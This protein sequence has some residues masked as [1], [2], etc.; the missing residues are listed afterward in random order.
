MGAYHGDNLLSSSKQHQ[1]GKTS[2]QHNKRILSNMMIPGDRVSAIGRDN[3]ICAADY[4]PDQDAAI[5][6]TVINYYYAIES[7][8]E[9]TT[10]NSAGRAIIRMLEDK[11][12][13]AIRPAILWCYFDEPPS[14][15]RN[16]LGDSSFSQQGGDLEKGHTFRKLTLDDARRLSIVSFS[17]SP[18]DDE[19]PIDCNYATQDDVHCIVMHGIVSI[20]HH[21]TSDVRLAVAS[22]YDST[23]K[24]MDYSEIFF[25]LEDEESL[26]NI[27]N[28]EWLGE[29]EQDAING[30]PNGYGPNDGTN[31]T[32][33]NGT[34]VVDVDESKEEED[35]N[36][37]LAYALSVP[38]LIVLA[39]ALLL[40]KSKNKRKMKTK[41]QL[42]AARSFHNVLIGTGD[43]PNS[44]HEGMYHYTQHGV[45]YLSTNCQTCIETKKNGFYTAADLDTINENSVE[46]DNYDPSGHRKR[47]LVS[48]SHD[49]LGLKHSAI[50]VHNCSSARCPICVYK[51]QDVEFVCK[52]ADFQTLRIGESEV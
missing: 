3:A 44:F 31:G 13:R 6:R 35:E 12:F 16:L 30:G 50:D 28:I 41:E 46:D 42:F 18:E 20:M 7:S 49:A 48:P 36:S 15:G 14:A 40:S 8:D 25:G 26:V 1:S 47:F 9:V 37:M 19:T 32:I 2:A 27:T 10:D 38:I 33:G 4:D 51:P 11:L 17:N 24:A 5:K 52:S 45:R 21:E 39:F 22:V 34:I 43:H 29:T 23:Q